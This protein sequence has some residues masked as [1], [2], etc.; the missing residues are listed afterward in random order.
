MRASFLTTERLKLSLPTA[1]D[2]RPMHAIICEGATGRYLGPDLSYADHFMRFARNAGSWQLY[3]Y[4][5]LMVRERNGDGQLIGN[6]GIFHS[7]R[8][9]GEDFD[10]RAEAGWIM[11]EKH[12]GRGYASEAMRAALNW[13]DGEFG[14]E[15]MCMVAPEN[16]ASLHLAE[17][18]GFDPT[19]EALLPDGDRVQLFRRP[20]S[21]G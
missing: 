9:L 8:G 17:K 10:D 13:F 14:T 19:R 2:M 12:Q 15:V 11:A 5:G 20:A 6:C 1:S 4:G 18:L 3:G 16:A 7:V 21:G